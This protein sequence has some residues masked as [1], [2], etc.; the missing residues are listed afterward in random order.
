MA[1]L[2]AVD[3]D[4]FAEPPAGGSLVPVE[5]DPFGPQIDFNR[6]IPEVRADIAKLPPEDRKRAL[7]QWA[8]TFVAKERKDGGVGQTIDNAVRTFS[9]GTFVGPYLDEITAFTNDKL[10]DYTGGAVG[11]PY[12]ETLAYQRAK[13]RAVDAANPTMST[14][15]KIAGGLAGGVAALRAPGLASAIVG[16]PFATVN[17]TGSMA[18]KML[19]GAAAGGVYGAAA[20]FGEGENSAEERWQNAIDTGR[21]GMGIGAVL[22]PVAAGASKVIGTASEVASPQV[23]RLKAWWNE[24]PNI[25]VGMTAGP[26]DG[27]AAGAGGAAARNAGADAAAEQ[28]IAN[29]LNRANVAPGRLAQQVADADEAARFYSNSRAQNVIAPVDLDP[30]LQR[31]AGSVGRQQPE[32]ANTMQA[33]QYARQTGQ[34][35]NTPLPETAGLPTRPALAR[36]EP[37]DKPMGQFERVRDALKRSL[38]IKDTDFHGHAGNAYRT[39]QSIL[40]AAKDEAKTLYDDA[41]QASQNINIRSAI[42]PVLQTWSQ[43]MADEPQPVANAIKGAMRLFYS[44]NGPVTNLQRFDKAKQ[45]LDG[46]I[47]KLFDSVEGRNRYLGG[48][49]NQFK[50]D[51]LQQIDTITTQGVGEKYAAARAAFSSRME[52]RDALRLGQQVFRE[53]ADVAIDQFRELASPGLQK[54]FRLGMLDGFEKQMGRQKRTADITQVF[55]NP[56]VQE[57]LQSVI[58]RTETATGRAVTGATF[59]DRPERFGRY[60]GNEK[61]MVATR[62]EVFGNSKTAQRLA[63]DQAFETL[64][65]VVDHFRQSPSLVNVGLKAMQSML[66]RM[67]GM[68]ADTAASVSRM[69]FTADPAERARVI[70]SIQRRMGPSRAVQFA[71][72]MEDYQ[73]Q[74]AQAGAT[75]SGAQSQRKREGTRR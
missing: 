69:L 19:Q 9:R 60:I 24:T 52:A 29:Q 1:Q 45:Y 68:R 28:V 31:L 62:N 55:E 2:V 51:L 21:I 39:E 41:Y 71:R 75:A 49:L 32:A 30:S 20:G 58:P 8:D 37:G 36:A 66:D 42:D 14:T 3:H 12:D 15:G 5:Y 7:K 33:F 67:F 18:N 38:L 74:V 6:S 34:T 4:P 26:L 59:A 17:P 35:P 70:E 50:N 73:R 48:V 40:Q 56:R 11:A 72:M 25:S 43:R 47:E 57:I 64:S 23:A 22:P 46:R 61:Q 63:D 27:G 10:H 54:L 53:D 65:S 44:E 13:D 16:G